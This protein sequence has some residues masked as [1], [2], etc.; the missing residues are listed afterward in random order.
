MKNRLNLA[1]AAAAVLFVSSWA[2]YGQTP[3]VFTGEWDARWNEKG[4][5]FKISLK[6]VGSKVEGQFNGKPISRGQVVFDGKQLKFIFPFLRPG[7]PRD[8]PLVRDYE[9]PNCNVTFSTQSR[10]RETVTLLYGYVY[11]LK[12]RQ[13]WIARRK[14][15]E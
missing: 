1:I 8:S 7:A 6:V 15:G 11:F 13:S 4:T 10:V 2:T 14:T 5:R 12:G 3:S 9:Y